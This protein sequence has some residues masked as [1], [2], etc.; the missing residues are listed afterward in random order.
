MKDQKLRFTIACKNFPVRSQTFILNQI[1][2]LIDKG[3]E[4]NI[5]VYEKND[6]LLSHLDESKYRLSEKISATNMPQ[7]FVLRIV[8]LLTFTLS[9]PA[10]FLKILK[11][12]NFF[13][14]GKIALSLKLFYTAK[15]F[16]KQSKYDLYQA[17]FGEVGMILSILKNIGVIDGRIITSFHGY[18]AH[19]SDATFTATKTMYAQ[20]FGASD[21]T[22]TV[23][24]NYTKKQIVQLGANQSTIYDLP[25]GLDTQKYQCKQKSNLDNRLQLISVG[26]LVPFKGFEYSIQ[27]VAKLVN[28]G[29]KISYIIIGEG[30][31][32]VFLNM[33]IKQLGMTEHIFL[34]G[35]KSQEEVITEM[36]NS[37]LFIHPAIKEDNGRQENQGLVIQEAQAQLEHFCLFSGQMRK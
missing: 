14:F 6:K 32:Y 21:N 31:Q 22:F 19:F 4:V 17:H 20:L 13:K 29:H 2:D 3:H 9:H 27:A 33:L 34:I 12:I 26:R 36:S 16:L 30:I 35:A 15:V 23:N 28:E 1:L 24:S 5:V 25:V 7:S 37:N 10:F 8:G 18:D 11:S